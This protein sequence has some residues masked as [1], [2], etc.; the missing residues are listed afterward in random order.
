MEGGYAHKPHK[1]FFQQNSS[2][3]FGILL[4]LLFI[5][6]V[7]NSVYLVSI[8]NEVEKKSSEARDA[9]RPAVLQTILINPPSECPG[10][11][12]KEAENTLNIFN[13]TS[14]KEM[15]SE[16][17]ND[18]IAKYKI[19]MLPALLVFGELERTK[20]Q[21]TKVEDAF[22]VTPLSA[23]Y[24]DLEKK[25]VRGLVEMTIIEPDNCEEC[26]SLDQFVS[27][28]KQQ[29]H[30]VKTTKVKEAD[31]AVFAAKYNITELPALLLSE[32][33]ALYPTFKIGWE[34][35]ANIDED[36]TF[37]LKEVNP[38]YKDLASGKIKGLVTATYI[39]DSSCKECYPVKN[40]QQ[41]LTKNLGVKLVQE[42]ELDVKDA[43]ALL[44]KYNITKVPTVIISPEIKE[45][46]ADV[47]LRQVG[48][49][50]TDGSFVFRSVELMGTYKDLMSGKVIAQKKE[51]TANV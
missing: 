39:A 43:D 1:G 21:F 15:K 48:T 36:G 17:A 46:K 49:Y 38:P 19:K 6:F 12:V 31:A 32:E 16:E 22:V 13:I 7:V 50:E 10:C 14:Q 45:Y 28:V 26:F 23:P 18:L 20:V 5:L 35:F 9:A 51:D 11:S 8:S 40:H 27:V 2:S 25:S 41:I 47:V 4:V 44:I 33:A 37:V 30:V 29:V 42:K 34:K 24:Y 3:I